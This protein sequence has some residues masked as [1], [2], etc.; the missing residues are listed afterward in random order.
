MRCPLRLTGEPEGCVAIYGMPHSLSDFTIDAPQ[1]KKEA[2]DRGKSLALW[3]CRGDLLM[4]CVERVRGSRPECFSLVGLNAFG[5]PKRGEVQQCRSN[6]LQSLILL[7]NHK[8]QAITA[9]AV[10]SCSFY[11]GAAISW[12]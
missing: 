10:K 5:V 12:A 9:K 8:A 2:S 4:G 11:R 1:R 3:M 7:G 6:S